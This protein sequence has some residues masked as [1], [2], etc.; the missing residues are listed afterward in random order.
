MASQ[1]CE[2][3]HLEV[4]DRA[5]A[6]GEYIWRLVGGGDLGSFLTS[7]NSNS[8]GAGEAGRVGGDLS[9]PNGMVQ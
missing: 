9:F 1:V 3:L 5:A 2:T 6:N 4:W 7:A 8:S